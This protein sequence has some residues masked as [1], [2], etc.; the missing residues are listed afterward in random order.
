[1]SRK[2]K[3]GEAVHRAA[4]EP[5]SK[6]TLRDRLLQAAALATVFGAVNL[7]HN[8]FAD[9]DCTTVGTTR[10]C[11]GDQ[12][13]GVAANNV[14]VTTLNVG[15]LTTE[16]APFS[17]GVSSPG[18]S[19]VTAGNNALTGPL[20]V[21]V[22]ETADINVTSFFGAG[23]LAGAQGVAAGPFNATG[24]NVT[25][26]SEATITYD[27]Q[28]AQQSRALRDNH[29]EFI[30]DRQARIAIGENTLRYIGG[31]RDPAA[32]QAYGAYQC[33]LNPFWCSLG[34]PG[35]AF[36]VGDPE[37]LARNVFDFLAQQRIELAYWSAP[38]RP[39]EAG[40]I[41]AGIWA[42]SRGGGVGVAGAGGD[43]R[44]IHT[45]DITMSGAQAFGIRAESFVVA[46]STF[47]SDGG[48]VHVTHDGQIAILGASSAGIYATSTGA[49]WEEGA[50]AGAVTVDGAG[51]VFTDQHSSY[52]I[53]AA[54][55][56]GDSVVQNGTLGA[57]DGGEVLVSYG[58]DIWTEGD[59]GR[60]IIG[61]SRGGNGG[62]GEAAEAT[63][64]GGDGQ[65]AEPGGPAGGG[66]T[67]AVDLLAGGS[68]HTEGAG[69][70]ALSALS[71]G[72]NGGNGG[73]G[74]QGHAGSW[75]GYGGDGGA[76]NANNWGAIE[77]FGD[78]AYGVFVQS[79]GG[80]G[81]RAGDANAWLYGSG[82]DGGAAGG[83]GNITADNFGTIYTSG[84][85]SF[86][87]FAETVGGGGGAGGDGSGILSSSGG[88]GG[89][90]A[91]HR[92]QVELHCPNG[93]TIFI[94]NE[95][96]IFTEGDGAHDIFAQSIG[97][98]GGQGGD[99]D[100]WINVSG[101]GGGDAGHGQFVSVINNGSLFTRGYDAS[102]IFAQSI[103][104]GGG[105]GGDAS[106]FGINVAIA[107]G[108]TGGAGGDGGDVY[109]ENNGFI[110]TLG[111]RTDAI[112]AQSVGGGGGVGGSATSVSAGAIYA[113]AVAIGGDGGSGGDGHA[114]DVINGVDGQ[115]V[116]AGDFSTGIFAQSVGGGGGQGGSAYAFAAAASPDKFSLAVG[117]TV[118]GS[119]GDGGVGGDVT[120]TNDGAIAT[121]DFNSI[122][123]LAQSVGG[124][125]GV[126][127]ASTAQTVTVQG[128]SG[129]SI[130]AT[131]AVGGTGGDGGDA[132]GIVSVTNN[133]SITTYGDGSTGVFAQSV[134]GGGGLGGDASVASAA[135]STGQ[136]SSVEVN[137]AVGGSG[138]A[139]GDGGGVTVINTGEIVTL[140]SMANGITAQS[141]GGGGGTGGAGS[142]DSL[143][144]DFEFPTEP[145]EIDGDE[146]EA[147]R[148][149]ARNRMNQRQQDARSAGANSTSAGRASKK[150]SSPTAAG[151]GISIGGD[152]GRG[153]RGGRGGVVYVQNDGDI[154]TGGFM[155]MGVFAQSIG[156]GGGAGGG[157]VGGAPG[158]VSIGVGAGGGGG[159]AD[160][161]GAVTVINGGSI[162]TLQALSHG[163]FA[164]SVGGRGGYGGIGDSEADDPQSVALSIGGGGGNGGLGGI[165]DV[166]QTG[167]LITM[168]FGAHG[169][170]AQS[171]GGGGGAGGQASRG[172]YH[173]IAI[174]GTGA[175]GSHG[176]DVFADVIGDIAT[177][178]DFAYG[179]FAQS[180]GG[181][182]GAAGGIDTA[183][184]SY[185]VDPFGVL[186][187][188][189]G[190]VVGIG[191]LGVGGSAG[192]GGDGGFVDISTE[193]T[194]TTF[195]L[196]S[197]GIFAQ[198]VGGG[199]GVGGSGGQSFPA[200]IALN[201][202]NGG[203]GTSEGIQIIHNGNIRTYGDNSAGLYAQSMGGAG[204]NGR[205]GAIYIAINGTVYGGGGERGVG[206]FLS[207]GSDNEVWLDGGLVSARSGIA[208][209]AT[210]GDDHIFNGGRIE[211]SVGLGGG[212]NSFTNFA[213]GVFA[214]GVAVNIGGGPLMNHGALTP[215]GELDAG[216]TTIAGDYVQSETGAYYMNLVFGGESDL[217]TVLGEAS[218]DGALRP[219]FEHVSGLETN[220]WVTVLSADS[221]ADNGLSI[222]VADTLVIDYGLRIVGGDLQVG[223]AAIE[224]DINGLSAPQSALALHIQSAWNAG[225]SP[226]LDELMDYLG[227]LTDQ[228]TYSGTLN[229]LYPFNVMTEGA[230]PAVSNQ[231]FLTGLMSCPGPVLREQACAW[232]RGGA[233]EA[234]QDADGGDP[235]YELDSA[236]FQGGAQFALA[237]GWFAGVSLGY[238]LGAFESTGPARSESETVILGGVLK[239][240]IGN[241]LFAGGLDYAHIS[242]N[243]SRTITF[244]STA[245]ATSESEDDMFAARLRVSYL[246]DS[247]AFYARPSLDLDV[248]QLY[249]GGF[250]ELGAGPL[251]FV[252]QDGDNT[253][254]AA[255]LSLELGGR[256]EAGGAI[257][258]PF[259]RIGASAFST[260]SI[261]LSARFEGAPVAAADFTVSNRLPESLISGQA[262]VDLDLPGVTAL[263][264]DYQLREGDGY[265]DQSFTAKLRFN[266]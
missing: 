13:D 142:Q 160:S 168:G 243:R 109:V 131:I 122:G 264:L 200:A 98:G 250:T 106:A 247:G 117:V 35:T 156:G 140:G 265:E 185:S 253:F 9:D 153:G 31:A 241:W 24:S 39:D 136:S 118:G 3:L 45:G 42:Y 105:A 50:D 252:V 101:G 99:A 207:G 248:Y 32:V 11:E 154:L 199:G 107:I 135:F 172:T 93:G 40:L 244:P 19:L 8:A 22:D 258:H 203:A 191:N 231:N 80:N 161:G 10:T 20:A 163:I 256:F 112:F 261:D 210:D 186:E 246:F 83:G 193:G 18:V 215:F 183:T 28:I 227:L 225:G 102:A 222:D 94:V 121:L 173:S 71:R 189:T 266:F 70:H 15:N 165:V 143:F 123:I 43:V 170:F 217:V 96:V 213:T 49:T 149:N 206:L 113:V 111:E 53:Y 120:V 25:V 26:T 47:G 195:G 230:M 262:G 141:V 201:G 197:H 6:R 130:N 126:G 175:A 132:G 84:E 92:C 148:R 66:G 188:D 72:G 103:G 81:G 114:V 62:W 221:I 61:I 69:A 260:D 36:P 164:Q 7:G 192:G 229:D 127:G 79:L 67:V 5:A 198:S 240:E 151:L 218:L 128:G 100:G 238:E 180:V 55:L 77:T 233:L 187:I 205:G 259:V 157:T 37:T 85:G 76:A 116:V 232:A 263:R 46:G 139:G 255:T 204:A 216:E 249:T 65:Q 202:S 33:L 78:H 190:L 167:D 110:S 91:T 124:G 86:G 239:R 220:Q 162:T 87:I 51:S 2:T 82:G 152:G 226:G 234:S 115:I 236:R 150:K 74:S 129:T 14:G 23:I 29:P 52:G 178:G 219:L 133:G 104:G 41:N 38:I 89:T 16:I 108:G 1:M 54:S 64:G 155:S 223:I 75:G 147:D 171:V 12:G 59:N 235:G 34:L 44:V 63:E 209:A 73:E 177:E 137:I 17:I 119:G 174:G 30:T 60:A 58:G 68:I 158:D 245:I 208:I 237:N 145:P 194:I 159:E 125:G 4:R 97:G 211:G 254:G 134:G 169:V 242:Y 144:E 56:G 21:N 184:Y 90:N 27:T 257:V 176:G 212:A 181:G 146:S 57:G 214:S 251:G 179:V 196:G 182:G 48:A 138:G 88:N 228:Q 95:G 166:Q 224:Y